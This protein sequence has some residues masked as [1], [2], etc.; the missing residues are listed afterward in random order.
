MKSPLPQRS[1]STRPV[2]RAALA[3]TLVTSLIA[4]LFQQAPAQGA[5]PHLPPAPK[6]VP[7]VPTKA[8]THAAKPAAAQPKPAADRPA[9][10]WPA[11]GTQL[12]N[13]PAT[14]ASAA[15]V[16]AG[17]LPVRVA[18]AAAKAAD[19]APSRLQVEVL[20]QA[21]TQRAGIHGVALKV[22]RADGVTGAG[23]AKVSVDYSSFATAYGADW[24]TRLRMVSVPDCAATTPT[25]A[26]CA[27]TPLASTNDTK[28]KTVSAELSVSAVQTMV[29]ATAA[30]SG[31]AGDYTAT[32]L[33]PS[34]TWDVNENTGS[35][36]WSYPMRVPPS[37]G[38]PAPV[39]SLAYSSQSVDGQ[40]A[41]SN[42]QPSWIGE[43]FDESVGG[44]I[45]RRYV[46]CSKDM[47]SS[48][49]NTTKTGDLCWETDNATLSLPGHAGELLYN[50]TEGRWHLRGDDASRIERKTGAVNGDNDGEYWVLTTSN[51]VQYWFGAN[52][53]PGWAA[54]NPVTNS[55]LTVP[56][57]GNDPGEP[58]HATA[59]TSSDCVQAWR[60]QLDY[61]VDPLGNSMSYWYLKQTNK[62]ARNMKADDPRSYDRAATLD[63]I[64]YGTRQSGG[65]DSVLSTTTVA[66]ARVKFVTD[67]RCL[68]TCTTH[69]AVHWPDVPWDSSCTGTSCTDDWSPTFWSTTR[70]TSI[71]T[72]VRNGIGFRD[73]ERWT[74][75][76]LFPDPGDGTRAGL[77]LSKISHAGLVGGTAT[78]PDVLFTP[79]QM[80]NRVDTIDFAA[81]MN[82]MRIRE[83]RTESGG[84]TTVDYSKPEC[85]PGAPRPTPETNTTR[86][87]PV[88]W[89]PDGYSQPVTDWFNK[90][91]V[92]TIYEND[93]TGG[94]PPGGSPR[95]VTSYQYFDGAAWHYT[96]DDGLV[97]A[98]YKTWSDYRGYGRV[99]V[100]VG[101]P[102]EQTYTETRYFR[103]MN[104]DRLNASGG[105]KPVSIDGIADEDWYGG[106][107]RETKTLNGPGGAVVTRRLETPWASPAT[108][109]RTINGDT[110][111]ARFVNVATVESRT[112]RDGGRADRV[113]KT[114][115]TFD[116]YGMPTAIDDLGDDSITG[117]ERCTKTDYTPRNTTA[118]ILDRVHEQQTYAV[119]CASTTGTLTD[120]DI[121]SDSRVSFDG[122]AFKAIPTKGLATQRQ[123]MSAYTNGAAT[124]ITTEKDAYDVHGRVTS[125]TD[126][127]NAVTTTAYTPA[128]DGPVTSTLTTNPLLHK[129]TTNLEPAWGATTSTIDPNL[130]QTSFTYS[131]LGLLTEVYK[132]GLAKAA[133]K[134]SYDI[135]ATSPTVV[136]TSKLNP[137]GTYVTT[138]QLLD[139]MLRPRQTQTPSPTTGRVITENFY[140]SAGRASLSFD[141]YNAAGAAS[142][143]L[144]AATDRAFVPRQNRTVYDGAGRVTAQIFQPYGTE[145]WRTTTAYGGDRT[146]VTP[147]AGGTATSTVTDARDHTIQ[148]R[149][150]RGATPTPQTPGSWDA[151]T[152]NYDRRGNQTSVVDTLGNDWTYTYDARGRQTVVDDPDKGTTSYTYDNAGNVLTQTDARGKK[153]AYLYDTLNRRRASY[154]NQVG[155][156]LRAQWIYDTVAKGQL[157]QST[158]MVGS[159]AY[160]IK[161]LDYNDRY[162]PGNVQVIIPQSE[163]GL[164]GTYTYTN[165][166][167]DDD[168]I[169]STS[170]PSTNSGLAAEALTFGYTSLGQPY[171]LNSLYGSQN[172]SYVQDTTYNALGELDQVDRYTG[173]GGHVWT[174]YTRELETGRTTGIRT[175]A[176]QATPAIVANVQYRYDNAGNVLQTTDTA[177]DP[178][179]DTQCFTYD[180][181]RRLTQAWTPAG[182]DCAVAPSTSQLGG[183]AP[184]WQSWQYDAIGN[185]TQETV[186]RSVGDAVTSYTYPG[187]GATVARP[188][189]ATGTTGAT[190]GSYTYDATGNMLTRP[191]TTAGTQ[192]MTWDPE[193]HLDTSTD[194]TGLN[195][196][197]Y[198]ADG[199]RLIRRDP[200]GRTLY[201]P[202]QEIRYT[203]ATGATSGT[204]YYSFAGSTIVQRTAT[205]LTWLAADRLGTAQAAVDATTQ[206]ATIRRQSPFGSPRGTTGTWPNDKGLVGGTNDNTGLTHIGA[207]EYDPTL[208]KFISVDPVQDLNDPQQWNAYTYSNNNPITMS[209]PTGLH[210]DYLDPASN[211]V[212]GRPNAVRVGG[213]TPGST[214]PG[215]STYSGSPSRSYNIPVRSSQ[216]SVAPAPAATPPAPAALP[217]PQPTP[218]GESPDAQ[219]AWFARAN[220]MCANPLLIDLCMEADKRHL[221]EVGSWMPYV[222]VPATAYLV[223]DDWDHGHPVSAAVGV[224]SLIP[225]GKV[226]SK[227]AKGLKLTRGEQVA[228]NDLVGNAYRDHIA[229]FFRQNGRTVVTD[230]ENRKALTFRTPD[231]DRILDMAVYD[232]N[233]GLLGYVETKSGKAGQDPEQMAKDAYLRSQGV[234]IAYVYDDM[235]NML[236]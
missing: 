33:K 89:E 131:P 55:A 66:P 7:L 171:S 81:A 21:A 219:A 57:F 67:D 24:S 221:A 56:V 198:D 58:C 136:S 196:Y 26:G 212:A 44:F 98:K 86:C 168:S 102:G 105:T 183:P 119:K 31:P 53:L 22:A 189:A 3:A 79:V 175:D 140:D 97:K 163:T 122:Q 204:R 222:G 121:M 133:V 157:S 11:A 60:W 206:K 27:V 93:N 16:A 112:A 107:T 159:A 167:N 25:K 187:N 10:V 226:F 45:E 137:A 193:G 186:H 99:G 88:R 173:T 162:K 205:G 184:Y 2:R 132:P 234:N 43:G 213:G 224:V 40:Q 78:V 228:V 182:G 95:V 179:D 190:T 87:Y 101:D 64:D 38:G 37:L 19:K 149:Q 85:L 156:T 209:D 15:P 124:F 181:L 34:S 4:G 200:T 148:L 17:T 35:F 225:L 142:G 20:D 218:W 106:M 75:T 100:T 111:T 12:V 1:P 69:D 71:T 199:N 138:Y 185:R 54:G 123:E 91:V 139:G 120:A 63:H 76:H 50:A 192:T 110:V 144:L 151:T 161:V 118:W 223:K 194:S 116:A 160:Q 49:N 5:V 70:L 135:N 73:V 104:G 147:P 155:G 23:R 103:G 170:I 229:D 96:D 143:T 220:E 236:Y 232:K 150:Y 52:R 217:T 202:N 14:G 230:A 9:P 126:A 211:T 114:N 227:A 80:A 30:P 174:A 36:N 47:G 134:Y 39:L 125:F 51:G 233:G 41:A 108:A 207:R 188:H 42:N 197:I 128:T 165:T 6:P 90:Y 146:D 231:G 48:A 72:Q 195:T 94:A 172:L 130:K 169:K 201:L 191:T 74:L 115:T 109:T 92:T 164:A 153:V 141:A 65:V 176:E 82:W 28:A 61:V 215:E 178:V 208:G 154:D 210:T 59:Y 166:Y 18:G 235:E 145:R 177:P 214:R 180:N 32:S 203:N 62:Y 84:T 113:T 29:A 46:P 216:P 8:V 129:T 158:R 68:S 13:V 83:I 127:M 152:Y 117:D 77:W